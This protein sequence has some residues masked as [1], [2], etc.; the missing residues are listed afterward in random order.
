MER[1][2]EEV[3]RMRQA[4]IAPPEGRVVGPGHPAAT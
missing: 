4:W 3:A 2:P 1:S